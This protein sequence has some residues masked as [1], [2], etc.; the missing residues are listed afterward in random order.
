MKGRLS[1]REAMTKKEKQKCSNHNKEGCN[2]LLLAPKYHYGK[3][4]H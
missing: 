4:C 2:T 1:F 3:A